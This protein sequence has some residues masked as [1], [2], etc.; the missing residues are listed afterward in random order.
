MA[1]VIDI[2]R[3]GPDDDHWEILDEGE[4]DDDGPPAEFFEFLEDAWEGE[5]EDTEGT[6]DGEDEWGAAE[7]RTIEQLPISVETYNR[8]AVAGIETIDE[9]A[10]L[11]EKT[12]RVLVGDDGLKEIQEAMEE[13][14][15]V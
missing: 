14:E 12:M 15:N 6:A 2:L 4:W 13:I 3:I 7:D 1:E 10:E 5:A 8:L 11:K 9:L